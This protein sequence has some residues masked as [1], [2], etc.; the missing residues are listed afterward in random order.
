MGQGVVQTLQ[1]GSGWEAEVLRQ[2]LHGIEGEI[3]MGSGSVGKGP[4]AGEGEAGPAAGSE[5]SV[6]GI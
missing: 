1:P 2:L 3:T 5:R 4:L 6:A